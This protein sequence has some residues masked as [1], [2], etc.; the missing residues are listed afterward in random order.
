MPIADH[1]PPSVSACQ[2]LTSC[3]NCALN[4]F[5]LPAHLQDAEIDQLNAIVRRHHPLQK[6]DYLFRAGDP[7]HQVYAL[8]SGALKT[9]LLSK[10]GTERITG[11]HLPGE[12]IGLDALGTQRFPSYA[13]AL[14][15]SQ[16]CT[17]P[18]DQLEELAGRIPN[19]RKQL[20]NVLGREIH[21][22]Q[23]RLGSIRTSADQRLATFLLDLSVRF[24]RRGLSPVNFIL[25]MNRSEIGNY[26][27]LTTETISRLFTRYRQDGLIDSCGREIQ[28]LNLTQLYSLDAAQH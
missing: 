21:D 26:L 27:G 16:L 24:S 2:P 22:E 14:E 28:L 5:C 4:R 18:L 20:L 13:V 10:D 23:Q 8:R 11:F 6:D 19:L 9:Y 12:L 1:R 25:P 7:M 17:L 15:T 3:R